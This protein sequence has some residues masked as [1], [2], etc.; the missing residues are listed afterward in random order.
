MKRTSSPFRWRHYAP[1]VILICVRWYCRY[2]LSYRGLEEMMRER[3][4]AVDRVAGDAMLS[5]VSYRGANAGRCRGHAL[6]RKGQVKRLDGRDAV[7]QARF[8][9]G[10]FGVAAYPKLQPSPFA[11]QV[12]SCNTTE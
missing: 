12:I 6:M 3:G 7:G 4:L 5:L 10:L 8:V 9:E 11:F 1:D 2:Q